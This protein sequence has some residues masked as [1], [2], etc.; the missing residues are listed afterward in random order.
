MS[1]RKLIPPLM[2]LFLFSSIGTSAA[3]KYVWVDHDYNVATPAIQKQV[4]DSTIDIPAIKPPS[5]RPI[6]RPQIAPIQTPRV[7]PIGTTQCRTQSVYENGRW[8]NKQ[9]CR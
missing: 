9:I 4:C 6:Q 7:P 1:I 2:T 8:V 3:C 5:I